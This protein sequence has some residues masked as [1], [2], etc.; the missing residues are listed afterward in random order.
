MNFVKTPLTVSVSKVTKTMTEMT[1]KHNSTDFVREYIL[2][3]CVNCVLTLLIF[4]DEFRE[5]FG[6]LN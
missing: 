4:F 6:Y 1:K 3:S 5:F 2:C